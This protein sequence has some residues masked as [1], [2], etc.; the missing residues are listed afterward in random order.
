[1]K[2]EKISEALQ[3]IDEEYIEKA[4]NYKKKKAFLPIVKWGGLAASLAIVVAG[5]A[6]LM[7][8]L[9]QG[10]TPPPITNEQTTPV[11]NEISTEIVQTGN[12]GGI[13]ETTTTYWNSSTAATG[14]AVWREQYLARI[15]DDTYRNYAPMR[16]F[17]YYAAPLGNKLTD[18]TV[19]GF[20]DHSQKDFFDAEDFTG[21]EQIETLRAEV[22]EIKG[23][24]PEVAI[25]VKYLDQGNALTTTH[26]YTFVNKDVEN[27]LTSLADFYEKFNAERYFGVKHETVLIESVKEA[28]SKEG[29]YQLSTKNTEE[30][31][32]LILSLE[33]RVVSDDEL[34]DWSFTKQMTFDIDFDSTGAYSGYVGVFDNGYMILNVH[35]TNY[36]SF[37]FDIGEENAEMLMTYI[38]ENATL[39]HNEEFGGTVHMTTQTPIRE[40]VETTYCENE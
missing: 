31:R 21:D 20:W 10:V 14:E 32:D 9:E 35:S 1:M 3:N 40:T 23:V 34:S 17:E 36:F 27:Q 15:Q 11:T 5:T 38:E 8:Y 37:A 24:S 19:W 30:L 13:T 22:Y 29:Y 7:P 25:L 28:I 18:V 6:L 12:V 39:R 33:G 2:K 26:Y 4:A 16:A